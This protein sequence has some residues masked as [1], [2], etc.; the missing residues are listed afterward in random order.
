MVKRK[1]LKLQSELINYDHKI[2]KVETWY[3]AKL[4]SYDCKGLY[5]REQS[6][7][8]SLVNHDQD[9]I[10]KEKARSNVTKGHDFKIIWDKMLVGDA[11]KRCIN[12]LV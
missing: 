3:Y 8:R 7:D 4:C 12:C 10:K 9:I 11:M 6:Y 2:R 1:I 5:V